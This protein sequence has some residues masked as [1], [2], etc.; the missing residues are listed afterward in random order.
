MRNTLVL[1]G[2]GGI[3]KSPLDHI[4]K[5]DVVR[6]DPY[7]L[8]ATKRPR[9]SDDILYAHPKLRTEL[10][11]VCHAM[12]LSFVSLAKGIEWCPQ[13][14]LLFLKVRTDWQL[15]PL[16]RLT[17]D[18]LKAEIYAPAIPVLLSE[19]LIAHLFGRV[20]SIVLHPAN[21]KLKELSDWEEIKTKTMQNC[22]RRGD[23]EASALDRAKTVD[24][25][26]PAWSQMIEEGGTEYDG[27]RFPECEYTPPSLEGTVLLDHQIST[28]LLAKAAL[29]ERNQHLEVFFKADE[30]IKR[31]TKLI[32]EPPKPR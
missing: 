12:N 27:W 31:I 21:G 25:E 15:L 11:L 24:E 7:R 13:V 2:P 19:P 1:V 3:G 6:A 29:L 17:G 22:I 14:M 26:A 18:L 32:V 20:E 5:Q 28:L 4:L 16:G 8:R 9:G 30:E 10:H 23:K